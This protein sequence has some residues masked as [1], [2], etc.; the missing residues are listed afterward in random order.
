MSLNECSELIQ[1][2]LNNIG[3][4]H[5]RNPR[6][7]NMVDA[8]GAAIAR[9][10][11]GCAGLG[12]EQLNQLILRYIEAYRT[13]YGRNP[14]NYTSWVSAINAQRATATRGQAQTQTQTRRQ[15][16]PVG[17]F[18]RNRRLGETASVVAP[19]ASS[20]RQ[21]RTAQTPIADYM[22]NRRRVE[23]GNA[24]PPPASASMQTPP[25][26]TVRQSTPPATTAPSSRTR[27]TTS[28]T[29]RAATAAESSSLSVLRQQIR[30]GN[31][32][33][34]QVETY[35]NQNREQLSS[36]MTTQLR[37]E[38]RASEDARVRM[39]EQR[40]QLC[41]YT[42]LTELEREMNASHV[43]ENAR[44][45]LY[46][47]YNRGYPQ[48]PM[49]WL[50]YMRIRIDNYYIQSR[51]EL[52]DECREF[53]VPWPIHEQL[54]RH[55]RQVRGNSQS[56]SQAQSQ[57]QSQSSDSN[58]I[59]GRLVEMIEAGQYS[60]LSEL[61]RV[62]E[63]NHLPNVSRDFLRTR[64]AQMYHDIANSQSQSQA[65]SQSQ[66]R[67][68]NVLVGEFVSMIQGGEFSSLESLEEIMESHSLPNVHRNFL[69]RKYAEMN[70]N[71]TNSRTQVRRRTIVTQNN[72]SND[73][74]LLQSC[75]QSFGRI[76]Q[77][78]FKSL[79]N[80]LLK[81]CQKLD[82]SEVCTITNL[83]EKLRT[84]KAKYIIPSGY[85]TGGSLSQ[86]Q[87]DKEF[88]S[89]CS[90]MDHGV[91]TRV[92]ILHREQSA[93]HIRYAGQNSVAYGQGISK[94]FFQKAANQMMSST[95]FMKTE[96]DSD[97]V[98]INPE[99]DVSSLVGQNTRENRIKV[100]KFVGQF[101]SFLLINGIKTDLHLSRSIQARF[102]YTE[103][104][105]TRE[106]YILY[107]LLEF[108]DKR[109]SF[110]NLMR[111]P[112]DIE[113]SYLE[114]NDPIMLNNSLPAEA[115]VTKENFAKY[116][117]LTSLSMLK[118]K[119]SKPYLDALLSG[120]YVTRQKLRS[121][122]VKLP[123][124]DAMMTGSEITSVEIENII[125]TIRRTS[126]EAMQ[127]PKIE[128][129]FNILRDGINGGENKFPENVARE[130]T[131]TRPQTLEEFKKQLLFFWTGSRF[132]N[133]QFNYQVAV[134]TRATVF[135]AHTCFQQLEMPTSGP[136]VKNE[137]AMYEMLVRTVGLEG[138]GFA[139]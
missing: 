67:D 9:I 35:I 90:V 109:N 73:Q 77:P 24:V 8:N 3:A 83:D 54:V 80:K 137:R 79:G 115:P 31:A 17:T 131:S 100:F 106:D 41:Y 107:F 101:M 10:I 85:N 1:H 42:S 16:T 21:T 134:P 14:R 118:V 47:L 44:P 133:S 74:E 28:R 69:R 5:V 76:D 48:T 46:S 27:T 105:M 111:R 92:K 87:Q 2:R 18:M 94:I 138:F 116:L 56:Q 97:R 66:S 135:K 45:P 59:V 64:Y 96:E 72:V 71:N 53:Q 130:Q 58:A 15:Q 22:R 40:I 129:F 89:L 43:P 104:E 128:M 98:I 119:E 49:Q 7:G 113:H 122:D 12:D 91:I 55:Y 4:I 62:M 30:T 39:L 20:T 123:A 117:E 82:S 124:L 68:P 6:S 52:D 81:M 112:D 121:M 33:W 78:P 93:T 132:Y 60:S 84:L 75:V 37:R 125:S 32:T 34:Q 136:G 63:I 95:L 50:R 11:D 51:Q 61:E 102:L 29:R 70:H 139:G 13:Q 26:Q 108:A 65:Q 99:A 57:S 110:I 88:V 23:T 38:M 19:Q 36:Y 120:F 126:G 114:F 103:D 25:P 127:S 86:I